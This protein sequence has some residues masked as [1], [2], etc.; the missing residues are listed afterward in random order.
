MNCTMR[1]LAIAPALLTLLPQPSFALGE[2]DA[3]TVVAAQLHRQGVA[4]TK[5]RQAMRDVQGSRPNEVVWTIRCDEAFYR[6]T[7]IP[8]MKARVSPIDERR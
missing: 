3:A 4:C 5:P 2:E 6:V 7:L 1:F 8:R